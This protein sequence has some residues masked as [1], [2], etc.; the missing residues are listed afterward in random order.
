MAF[1]FVALFALLAVATAQH[2]D[3]HYYQPQ[4]Q[5]HQPQYHA[6]PAL[7]KTVQPALVKTIQPALVKTVK[8]VEYPDT[9]AEY[10][11]AYD[12]HDDQTGDIKSQQ[13]ER[14]GDN[15]KGVYTL[16]DADGYRRIVEYTADEHNGFNAVVR[17]EPLEGHKVVKTIAP[18]AKVAY[19]P[20]PVKYLA[21]APV[22][23]LA[24]APV[25]YV[26]PAPVKYIAPA[27]VT[28]VYSAPIA[29][30]AVP[31][32]AKVAYAPHPE[33]VNH[34][35]F[36]GHSANYHYGFTADDGVESVV[37]I[38]GVV[39]NA[40]VTIGIDQGVLSLDVI[41]VTL[42][43]LALDVSGVVIVDGVLELSGL[44]GLD[45]GWLDGLH[46]GRLGMV[47]GLVV[48]RLRLVVVGI[49]VLGSGHGQNGENCK[50]LE[51]VLVVVV[52]A[53]GGEAHGGQVGGVGNLG[54]WQSNLVDHRGGNVVLDWGNNLGHRE[55][56]LDDL[57]GQRFTA[58]DGV[59]SVVLIG[60]VVHNATVTIGI[61]QG[62][63]SLDVI[64]VTLLLLAL[65]VSGVVIVD[66]V[67]EL[68]LGG[69]IGVFHVL[70]GNRQQTSAGH[71]NQGRQEEELQ[72]N[73]VGWIRTLFTSLINTNKSHSLK[74]AFKFFLLSALIAVASAGLLPVA[75]K[76]VEYADAPAEYQFSYSVHDDH[77]GDI[78]SQ[79]E[80]RHGDDVKGQYT[81]IDADGYRRVVD[82]TADEHNGFNAVVRREPLTQK[83]VKAVLP[84]AKVVAPVQ[85]YVAAPVVHK[86]ALPVAKVAY[87]ANLATVSFSAP[88]LNYHY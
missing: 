1:K 3:P 73:K 67:R 76:H 6:Q 26:A 27:P 59:E 63:L 55:D 8:H 56:G 51:M 33:T 57:L 77:T 79:Q 84:V 43:L 65:D 22:K 72:W 29:K 78:K 38:G 10:Q 15:V 68:V 53:R 70:D 30:V 37:L 88:S 42:L 40:T 25:K 13:E 31:A 36:S 7:V 12:V 86:V 54:H 21:P 82:Y 16:I 18:V 62:V 19:A 71:G 66:G 4:P 35:Q 49:V 24:P 58:D 20:A 80:E 64:S 32:V 41:S 23:Y 83:V 61:D 47:L 69:G 39:D 45:D 11:F 2:Y 44:D 60:G 17:R 87:P 52:Q 46:Q 50:E 9:P 48:L 28:K 75:V 14:H 85:H 74:M 5:Y 34:V 81:L